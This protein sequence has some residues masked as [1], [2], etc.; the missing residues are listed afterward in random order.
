MK[1]L[2]VDAKHELSIREVPMPAYKECQAPVIIQSC[3]V[4]NG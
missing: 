1:T 4:C 2:V 3:G